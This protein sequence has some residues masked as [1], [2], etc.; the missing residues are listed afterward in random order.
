MGERPMGRLMV[1]GSGTRRSSN[2]NS[3][4]GGGEHHAR[5]EVFKTQQAST[6]GFNLATSFQT[7]PELPHTSQTPN[8]PKLKYD[9]SV[10][11]IV[12]H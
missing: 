6:N 8:R 12:D 2:R 10:Q 9:L 11:Q 5:S 7:I 1:G 4:L 3:M